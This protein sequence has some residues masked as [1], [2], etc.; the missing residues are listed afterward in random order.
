MADRR[1]VPYITANVRTTPPNG[2]CMFS[3]LVHAR[4]YRS[5][6]MVIGSREE[7]RVDAEAFKL[8]QA[9]ARHECG[10]ERSAHFR[11]FVANMAFKQHCKELRKP[12]TWGGHLE[13]QAIAEMDN[14]SIIIWEK[15]P[16]RNVYKR[17]LQGGGII[18]PSSGTSLYE[19]HLLYENGNHYSFLFNV[20]P[21]S[22]GQ[23]EPNQVAP[24]Q[25]PQQIQQPTL[26]PPPTPVQEAF[27]S[28]IPPPTQYPPPILPVLSSEIAETRTSSSLPA[29]SLGAFI[30]SS[31]LTI[32]RMR[33]S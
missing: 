3:A 2:N 28:P 21:F 25:R 9:I 1:S 6:G 27:M 16:V 7:N 18:A 17:H 8:R 12:G 20:K 19:Y 4:H 26:A 11:Q 23:R 22:N 24:Q 10:N 30:I 14:V 31:V 32:I 5:T 15:T 29:F 13:L 33:A